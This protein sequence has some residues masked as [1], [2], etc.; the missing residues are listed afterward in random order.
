MMTVGQS[1]WA[2]LA[3]NS[4]SIFFVVVCTAD[5]WQHNKHTI[6]RCGQGGFHLLNIPQYTHFGLRKQY[7]F[8]R[9]FCLKAWLT[10]SMFL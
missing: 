10:R 9:S 6:A 8:C 5:V 7:W 3:F 2:K 1:D 4:Y